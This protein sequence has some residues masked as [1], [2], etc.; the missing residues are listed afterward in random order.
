MRRCSRRTRAVPRDQLKRPR[1]GCQPL[2]DLVGRA[3]AWLIT[4]LA[5]GQLELE[6]LDRGV[7]MNTRRV[8]EFRMVGFRLIGSSFD[9]SARSSEVAECGCG[10][11][12]H[13]GLKRGVDD[14]SEL[15]VVVRGDV[16]G[17]PA[18]LLGLA[19]G[20]RVSAA[21]VPEDRL[22]RA[23]RCRTTRSPRSRIPAPRVRGRGRCRS[24][25]AARRRRA[26]S[27]QGRSR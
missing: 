8:E 16:I 21:D 20:G 11:C 6:R 10:D 25:C 14:W 12:L 19:V 5:S 4:D 17:D 24:S 2:R 27:D 26:G 13:A 23:I 22:G 3:R 15:G 18:G 9:G 1:Q 7:A